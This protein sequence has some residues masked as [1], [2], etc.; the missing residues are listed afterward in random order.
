MTLLS[1]ARDS[2]FLRFAVVGGTGFFVNEAVLFLAIRF[3]KFGAY[4]GGIFAF[5]VTV[6]FTWWGNRMLTFR[7]EA[8]HRGTAMLEEWFKFVTANAIG[9]MVNYAVYASL[10][11]FAPAPLNSPYVALAFGTLAGLIFN[12]TLSKRFVFRAG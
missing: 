10:V 1:R 2:R 6:T 5:L 3:L 12:F 7:D 9:F 8:A 11:T 4:A